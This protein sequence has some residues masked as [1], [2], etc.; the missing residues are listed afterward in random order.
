MGKFDSTKT[1][2]TPVF[3]RLLMTDRNG[4]TWLKKLLR[5]PN[6]SKSEFS[7]SNFYPGKIE[8]CFYGND[9]IKLEAPE[10]LLIWLVQ[11]LR[12][13]EGGMP[14]ASKETERK[15]FDLIKKNNERIKQAIRLI[16]KNPKVSKKW[17][18]LEGKSQPDVYIETEKLIVVI[19]GKRTERKSTTSTQWMDVRHQMLR[20][21]DAAWELKGSRDLYGFF[22]VESNELE[23]NFNKWIEYS[24]TTINDYVLEK[25]LPH[26]SEKQRKSISEAF[27]GVTSWSRVCNEL[28]INYDSLP[29]QV[30]K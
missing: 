30:D 25:S 8:N 27:L 6:M 5:L 18:I 11:N 19:E 10:S 12:L 3:D 13:P 15:R 22:I 29:N 16:K 7:Q 23:E 28:N 9:E 14:R 20:H 26:R 4:E 24:E 2:V 17:F 1:R 21:I